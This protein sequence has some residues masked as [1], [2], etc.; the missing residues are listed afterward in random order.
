MTFCHSFVL[1]CIS[2][3]QMCTFPVQYMRRTR[4]VGEEC[5]HQGV[6]Y[7]RAYTMFP[8]RWS[9]CTCMLVMGLIA[10]APLKPWPHRLVAS[11]QATTIVSGD[12]LDNK[13]SL[14]RPEFILKFWACA[15]V[16]NATEGQAVSRQENSVPIRSMLRLSHIS[17]LNYFSGAQVKIP[18]IKNRE[19]I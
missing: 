10:R 15:N 8:E 7:L 16:E 3:T 11:L 1:M 6:S 4:C 14:A 5:Y 17:E 2:L 12:E 9:W 19:K 18:L 13:A